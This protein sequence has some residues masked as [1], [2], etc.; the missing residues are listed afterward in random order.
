MN[1]LGIPSNQMLHV[2]QASKRGHIYHMH[3]HLLPISYIWYGLGL[4]LCPVSSPGSAVMREYVGT[5]LSHFAGYSI[6]F[7]MVFAFRVV[8]VDMC[9]FDV[10][11][12]C[13]DTG[14]DTA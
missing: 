6:R 11:L 1:L 12:C 10:P 3:T 14:T 4:L 2:R 8:E 5:R 7:I 13:L 9:G